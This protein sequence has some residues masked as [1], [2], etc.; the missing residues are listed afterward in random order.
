MSA[1]EPELEHSPAL[2][3]LLLPRLRPPAPLAAEPLVAAEAER[4]CAFSALPRCSWEE[5]S[6]GCWLLSPPPERRLSLLPRRLWRGRGIFLSRSGIA[7][8]RIWCDVPP[9]LRKLGGEG[10]GGGRRGK[11][12]VSRR[13]KGGRAEAAKDLRFNKW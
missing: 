5:D 3:P 11:G 13:R 8:V 1:S 2:L 6:C 12:T 9:A 10:R 7:P 4:R